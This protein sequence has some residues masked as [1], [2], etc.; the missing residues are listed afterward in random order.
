MKAENPAGRAALLVVDE[1]VAVRRPSLVPSYDKIACRQDGDAGSLIGFKAASV[2]LK[3]RSQVLARA[4]DDFVRPLCHGSGLEQPRRRFTAKRERAEQKA[5]PLRRQLPDSG[6]PSAVTRIHHSPVLI[7]SVE[8]HCVHT[9]WW[10]WSSRR[11]REKA[12]V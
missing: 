2:H 1:G 7:R 9:F 4:D 6:G 8:V 10:D 5:P 12:G 3:L 11:E